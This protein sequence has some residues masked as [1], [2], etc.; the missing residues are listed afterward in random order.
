MSF[1]PS[2]FQIQSGVKRTQRVTWAV[3]GRDL[4]VASSKKH[5]PVATFQPFQRMVRLC[6]LHRPGGGR[7]SWLGLLG[8]MIL[9]PNRSIA[10]T[11]AAKT[12]PTISTKMSW[13]ADMIS[14]RSN[15]FLRHIVTQDLRAGHQDDEDYE[16]S[17]DN[18]DDEEEEE[19]EPQE[20]Y[21]HHIVEPSLGEETSPSSSRSSSPTKFDYKLADSHLSSD[22]MPGAPKRRSSSKKRKKHWTQKMVEGSVNLTGNLAWGTVRQS[23]KLAYLMLR[24]KHVEEPETH[25]LWR[26]DQQISETSKRR[27]GGDDVIL[28]SVATLEIDTRRHCIVVLPQ[29]GKPGP[30]WIQPYEFTSTRLGLFQTVFVARAF[31]VGTDQ[32]RVYGYKGTWERKVADPTVLKMVGKIYNVRKLR[33]GQRGKQQQQQLQKKGRTAGDYE[34]VGKAIGTF[35]ARRRVQLNEEREGDED[36]DDEEE[37]PLDN[38][39]NHGAFIENDEYDEENLDNGDESNEDDVNEL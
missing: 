6:A 16:T 23:G 36:D 39:D 2:D 13:P 22:P 11:V 1:R 32:V 4:L 20:K 12:V 29:E 28:S 5:G 14:V 24:P 31:L 37:A 34:L 33:P 25:G 3:G 18:N 15:A 35:V 30:P 21:D 7:Y 10:C 26:L 38:E 27:R 17:D 8:M 9:H 19:E